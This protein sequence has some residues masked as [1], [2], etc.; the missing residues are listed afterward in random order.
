ML[1]EGHFHQ[2]IM[3]H[4]TYLDPTVESYKVFLCLFHMR[5]LICF[6]VYKKKKSGSWA[7]K[8]SAM[9]SSELLFWVIAACCRAGS[10]QWVFTAFSLRT[11]A[12]SGKQGWLE[13]VK[14]N[15][16]SKAVGCRTKTMSLNTPYRWC[17]LSHGTYRTTRCSYKCIFWG[18]G[19]ALTALNM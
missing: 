5:P 16:N 6:D 19:T 11:A 10:I 13:A 17:S 9:F 15:Q 18:D 4:K 3:W 2:E 14:L 12:V 1:C 8:C 7:A